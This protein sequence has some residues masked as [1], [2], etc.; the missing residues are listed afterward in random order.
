MV[1]GGETGDGARHGIAEYY[2]SK[3]RELDVT[4]AG[5][6]ANLRRLEAQ[7]NELNS[8]VRVRCGP[9]FFALFFSA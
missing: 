9:S 4:I 7:R 8:R 1:G 2:S 5:K 6:E 3:C